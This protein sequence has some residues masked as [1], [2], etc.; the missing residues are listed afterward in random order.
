MKIKVLHLLKFLEMK[1]FT[2]LLILLVLFGCNQASEP[3]ASNDRKQENCSAKDVKSDRVLVAEVEG[4]VCKMGC[5][6]AIRKELL[7]T[8]AVNLVEVEYEEEREKQVVRVH[9]DSKLMSESNLVAVMEKVNDG[10]F[11]VQAIGTQNEGT[12]ST[13]SRKA[14]NATIKMTEQSFEIPSFLDALLGIFVTK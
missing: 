3:K 12:T 4:M 8:C 2:Y 11:S 14:E 1:N 6:G 5:G 9:F 10:Q 13:D 7:G